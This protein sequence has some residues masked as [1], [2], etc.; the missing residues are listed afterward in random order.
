LEYFSEC[1]SSFDLEVLYFVVTFRVSR[2]LNHEQKWQ[3]REDEKD[4]R[5]GFYRL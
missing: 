4:K 5:Y 3:E 2:R 1:P